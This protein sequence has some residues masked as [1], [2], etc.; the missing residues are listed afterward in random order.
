VDVAS[1]S[2]GELTKEIQELRTNL[3]QLEET[4]AGG[5]VAGP[6]RDRIAELTGSVIT[7]TATS[8]SELASKANLLL[9]W[10][11]PVSDD[12][13]HRLSASLCRDVVLMFAGA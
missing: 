11:D 10:I 5:A 3:S 7:E 4:A 9:Y 6:V 13:P 8:G 12:I 2:I 1:V